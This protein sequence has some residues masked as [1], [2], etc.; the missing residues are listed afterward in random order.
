[1]GSIQIANDGGRRQNKTMFITV[2]YFELFSFVGTGATETEI[3][4]E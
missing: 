3:S 1:M 2:K 4:A